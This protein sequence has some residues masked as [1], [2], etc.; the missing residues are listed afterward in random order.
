MADAAINFYKADLRAIRFTLYD[1]LKVQRLFEL[2]EYSHLSREECDAIIDQCLRFAM[3]V[4]GP[5]NAAGDRAGCR[6][7]HGRVT[8]PPGFKEAWRTLFELGLMS[9][10]MPVKAG[11]FGG[12]HAIGVILGE[13]QSGANTAFNM[14]PG[15]THGAADLL[16]RFA[17]PEDQQRF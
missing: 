11:G 9:F 1:H 6:F 13:L 12:P 15:L 7:E 5:L 3:E 2:D 14:Y 16:E 8:T 10:T 4:T 17:L